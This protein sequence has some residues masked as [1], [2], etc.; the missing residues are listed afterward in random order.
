M[1][2]QQVSFMACFFLQSLL[3]CIPVQH[4]KASGEDFEV[5]FYVVLQRF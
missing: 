1:K 5:N 4:S 3:C 2:G